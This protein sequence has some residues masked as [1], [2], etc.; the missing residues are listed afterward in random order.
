V[1]LL[2]GPKK[3]KPVLLLETGS[4]AKKLNKKDSETGQKF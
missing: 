4:V 2:L 1:F 3:Q